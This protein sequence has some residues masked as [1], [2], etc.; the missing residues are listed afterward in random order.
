[1]R[2]SEIKVGDVVRVPRGTRRHST[3]YEVKEIV[4][5]AYWKN[6]TTVIGVTLDNKPSWIWFTKT[7]EFSAFSVRGTDTEFE[8]D[9]E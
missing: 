7:N 6:A 8:D 5:D 2:W 3:V 1:M 9:D 4:A